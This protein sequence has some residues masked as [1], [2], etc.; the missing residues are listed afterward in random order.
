MVKRAATIQ[1]GRQ[2]FAY[3]RAI[4]EGLAVMEAARRYLAIDHGAAAITAHRQVVDQVRAIA[5]R[6]GDS[7][8]RLIGIELRDRPPPV[9]APP[10]LDAWIEREGLDDW[11]EA[12]ALAL[13]EER[14]AVAD[15]QEARRRGRDERLRASRL[16]LL[17]ELEQTSVEEASPADRLSGWIPED[18]AA[19][20]AAI[21]TFTLGDLHRQI[22][23]GGRWW[24]NLAGFGPVKAKR[25]ER[26]LRFLLVHHDRTVAWPVAFAQSQLPMLDGQSGINRATRTGA[27]LAANT[28]REAVR[29]WIQARAR[30]PATARQ[31]EREAERFVLWC[32]LERGKAL[33]DATAEDCGAYMAF[34]SDVPAPWISRRKVERYTLG[35]APFAG[36]L[37]IASQ[38]LALTLLHSLMQWL[39]DA[40]YLQIN[41]WALVSRRLGDDPL[42]HQPG[43][44]SRAFTERAWAALGEHLQANGDSP[45]N[46]RL[47]WIC[48]FEE[49][50]GLRAAELLAARRGDLRSTP[51]G[52]LIDVRGKGQRN[53][54]VPVPSAAIE[55]TRR[56]FQ[57]KGLDFDGCA[58]HAPLLSALDNP[59]APISYSALYETFTRFVKRAMKTT[60][61]PMDQRDRARRASTHWLRHTYA[62]RAAERHV[63]ADVLQANLGQKDPR[64]TALYYRAQIERRQAQIER[65][66]GTAPLEFADEEGGRAPS[67]AA[68]RNR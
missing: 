6:R 10:S 11:S 66:F 68:G 52:W 64:T 19:R 53:R 44:E 20:F 43:S 17:T 21:G 62:T 40:G 14:F 30:S 29:A 61:L 46:A 59:L 4:S 16:A 41:P 34:L 12:E 22:E 35:W 60:V 63:D 36:P 5:R 42:H 13:Y 51:A 37:S 1:L 7:R 45:S 3:L 33:S 47:W 8:W 54:S 23:R 38:Q 15:P 56:Y 9:D 50:V 27:G 65:A 48:T 2:A 57:F 39:R 26:H 18:L 32:L 31:Y 55:A 28:D 25:L 67:A 49:A 24:S 58:A